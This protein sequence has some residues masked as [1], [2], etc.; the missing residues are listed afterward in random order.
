MFVPAL[1]FS[2]VW[3]DPGSETLVTFLF[4]V[5]FRRSFHYLWLVFA[6]VSFFVP[7]MANKSFVLHG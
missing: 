5:R 3:L 4:L 7:K 1:V 2:G 6:G